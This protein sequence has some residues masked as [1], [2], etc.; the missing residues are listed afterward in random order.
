MRKTHGWELLALGLVAL[1]LG[2]GCPTI[3]KIKER[4]VELAVGGSN[5][6]T[7]EAAGIVNNHDDRGSVDV[8]AGL[9]LS[10]VVSDAGI[11]VTNV[12]D[13]KLAGVSYRTTRQDPTPNRRIVNGTITIQRGGGAEVPLV[14]NFNADVNSATTYQGTT[15]NPAGVAVL[16]GLLADLLTEVK[17]GATAPNTTITYHVTGQS[18]PTGV[19]TDFQ[20][21]I[22]LDISILGTVKIKVLS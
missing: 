4:V 9:D 11:D 20:Y 2:A 6:V 19:A 21:E 16:N 3:P 13:V 17:G 5:S 12:E 8:R 7:I 15:L 1:T 18:T 14:D 10:K 22:K